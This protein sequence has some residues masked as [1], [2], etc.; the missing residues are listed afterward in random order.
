MRMVKFG[1]MLVAAM[2]ASPAAAQGVFDLGALTNTLSQTAAQQ[3]TT[4]PPPPP[5][6]ATLAKLTF[7]PSLPLRKQIMAEYFRGLKEL[8]P[9]AGGQMEAALGQ[10]DIIDMAGQAIAKY[11]LKTNDMAD[12]YAVYFASAWSGAT[13]YTPDL[14]KEQVAGVQAMSRNA[15]TSSKDMLA[16]SDEK[17]QRFTEMMI[18]AGI[19]NSI[20]VDA[21]KDD[22]AATAKVAADIK[23]GAKEFG[24]DT[25]AFK[26]TPTGIV[27]K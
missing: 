4:T 20:L 26:I 11:G 13:G 18:V 10:V 9:E 1:M 21:V 17:K 12:A 3:S 15:L 7:T 19:M 24:I 6:A 27:R 22:P 2:V 23:A 5:S 14:T 16:L 25:D 8:N